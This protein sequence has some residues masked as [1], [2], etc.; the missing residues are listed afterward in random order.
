MIKLSK[1]KL[2]NYL[3]NKPIRAWH[4]AVN[5]KRLNFNVFQMFV[6][7]LL[8][9]IGFLA[10]LSSAFGTIDSNGFSAYQIGIF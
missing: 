9:E 6:D 5:W 3:Y 10:I 4:S 7:F 2:F 8:V 1:K